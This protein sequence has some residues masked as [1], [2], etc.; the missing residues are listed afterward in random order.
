M[1]LLLLTSLAASIVVIASSTPNAGIAS[2]DHAFV[3]TQVRVSVLRNAQASRPDTASL[4]GRVEKSVPVRVHI[5]EHALDDRADSFAIRAAVVRHVGVHFVGVCIIAA[6]L[7]MCRR[8]AAGRGAAWSSSA[9]TRLGF[10]GCWVSM[11]LICTFILSSLP[12]A[13][14]Y[15][16]IG[17]G[18]L[19]V[20]MYMGNMPCRL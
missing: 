18:A 10:C 4:I 14:L 5:D 20:Y 9:L 15:V 7:G 1:K 6:M 11:I 8:H 16:P 17:L 19:S 13:F 3:D 2:L 12:L